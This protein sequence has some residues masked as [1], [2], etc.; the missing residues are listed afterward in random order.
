MY[1]ILV[2]RD[3]AS[4]LLPLSICMEQTLT[5]KLCSPH[6][7]TLA[8]SSDPSEKKRPVHQTCEK[9]LHKG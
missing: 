6:G 1:L 3:T 4:P 8:C 2:S 7:L 5:L 9:P